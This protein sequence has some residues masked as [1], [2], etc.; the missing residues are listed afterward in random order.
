MNSHKTP[1][2]LKMEESSQTISLFSQT[3]GNE[4]EINSQLIES[5]VDNHDDNLVLEPTVQSQAEHS[6]PSPAVCGVRSVYMVTYSRVDVLKCSTRQQFARFVVDEFEANGAGIEKW[7]CACEKHGKLSEDRGL[8]FHLAIKLKTPRRYKMVWQKLVQKYGIHVQFE[9]FHTNYHDAYGYV[10]KEDPQFVTSEGHPEMNERSPLSK[11]GTLSR[12]RRSRDARLSLAS[13]G[14]AKMKRLD[15]D[16]LYDLIVENKIEDDDEFCTLAEER[17]DVRL[18][19]MGKSEKN[20][21]ELIRTAWKIKKSKEIS[22]RKLKTRIQLLKEA[23][24]SECTLDCQTKKKWIDLA[25]DLLSK[26]NHQPSKFAFQVRQALEQGR[27]KKRNIL[28]YGPY[29]N[30]GKSFLF[31]P[32]G[33]IYKTF[34][35]PAQNNFA[36]VGA[37]KSEVVFLNDFRWNEKTIN[38]YIFL[39]L[40]EGAPVHLSAPKTHYPEDPLWTALTPIF[41]T[42]N[43][44]IRCVDEKGIEDRGETDMMHKRWKS[45]KFEHQFKKL[46]IIEIG[47]CKRCFAELILNY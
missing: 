10:T 25:L 3:I 19:V 9:E 30:S 4:E 39:N 40:L 27:G 20:R 18:F 12:R 6:S 14:N 45:F 22:A 15:L 36:W 1:C 44:V 23:A 38:W 31:K 33:E 17:N 37:E 42:S 7:V 43:N 8:H 5:F 32:L 11:A 41:A 47:P 46:D 34:W 13:G 16:A 24:E 29:P 28:I 2:T 26:N 35:T 21:M